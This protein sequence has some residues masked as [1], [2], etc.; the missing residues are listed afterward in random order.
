MYV[1]LSGNGDLEPISYHPLPLQASLPQATANRVAGAASF[2]GTESGP[3][4]SVNG[5]L[6]KLQIGRWEEMGRV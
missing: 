6:V 3:G 5:L 1:E 2:G 4:G